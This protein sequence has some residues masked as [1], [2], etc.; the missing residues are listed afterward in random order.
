MDSFKT[1]FPFLLNPFQLPFLPRYRVDELSD[2]CILILPKIESKDAGPY[3]VIFPG[4]F[5]DNSKFDVTLRILAW[6]YSDLALLSGGGVANYARNK[7]LE[8]RVHQMPHDLK[9]SSELSGNIFVCG[10]L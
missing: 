5:S 2:A 6:D 10:K 7:P 9:K 3:K 4:R 1:P 8:A